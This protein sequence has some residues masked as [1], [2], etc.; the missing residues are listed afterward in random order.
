MFSFKKKKQVGAAFTA[1]ALCLFSVLGAAAEL[2]SFCHVKAGSGAGSIRGRD[3][4]QRLPIASVSKVMTTEWAISKLGPNHR[5]ETQVML[6]NNKNGTWD[7]HFQGSRDPYFGQSQMHYLVSEL[8]KMGITH[9]RNMTFDWQFKFT[10]DVTSDRVAILEYEVDSPKA[11][12]VEAKLREKSKYLEG[13]SQTARAA[14]AK[15]I[16][17]F[18]NPKFRVDK[19]EEVDVI[20]WGM[21]MAR[22]PDRVRVMRSAPLYHLLR[23]MNRN[24]N[25]Y[26]AN[27]IF[28]SLGGAKK[29][30]DYVQTKF[31]FTEKDIRFVN[32]HGAPLMASL[33][34]RQE[35][36][37]TGRG[38]SLGEMV[39]QR[40]VYVDLQGNEVSPGDNSRKVYNEASC[41]AVLQVLQSLRSR[42]LREK[43]DLSSVMVAAGEDERSTIRTY[44][45]STTNRSLIA[46]TGTVNTAITLGGMISTRQGKVLFFYNM[47]PTGRGNARSQ[48]RSRVTDLIADVYGGA[49][50]ENI[51][52][53]EFTTFSSSGVTETNAMWR[54]RMG[55]I[56]P[57]AT[58]KPEVKRPLP[59]DFSNISILGLFTR[60]AKK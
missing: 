46:K 15:G 60:Q 40:S 30:K 59:T 57:K 28:E 47:R 26:A 36:R 5:F 19:V 2:N 50:R 10:W 58:E 33:G 39:G 3:V 8:N 18:D 41:A 13:Y 22:V 1:G 16:Q 54:R 35:W 12:V 27:Q 43:K 21:Q 20:S 6:Y 51:H 48:I 37:D 4:N 53:Q 45:N 34:G 24:S 44:N 56:D 14:K 25:N 17:F 23:E 11:D 29:Y 52:V 32:G 31:G 42:L 7:L 55:F 9:I 49:S 38:Y